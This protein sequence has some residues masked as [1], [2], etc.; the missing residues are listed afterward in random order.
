MNRSTAREIVM[1]LGFEAAARDLPVSELLDDFFSEEHYIT[2]AE[3]DEAFAEFPDD[4]QLEFIKNAVA[5]ISEHRDELDN[6]IEKYSEG[7]KSSRISKTAVACMRCA[8]CE[9][10]YMDDI[11]QKVSV[12][13]AV[14][15]AKKYDEAEVVSFINGILGSFLKELNG[16]PQ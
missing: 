9:I 13:E 7:W 11:P 3:E 16:A 15:I 4:K 1:R 2:L 14:E 6:I 8:I 10:L 5:L 12:N